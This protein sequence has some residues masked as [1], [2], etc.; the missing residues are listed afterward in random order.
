MHNCTY[1]VE[2]PV[3]TVYKANT[4]SPPKPTCATV[5][6]HDGTSTAH[7]EERG[8]HPCSV[9]FN[10]YGARIK[11]ADLQCILLLQFRYFLQHLSSCF[12]NFDSTPSS[13]AI[14]QRR[15][16]CHFTQLADFFAL[17]INGKSYEKGRSFVWW[18]YRWYSLCSFKRL[19]TSY[20]P[21]QYHPFSPIEI[22]LMV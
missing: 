22:F 15:L 4:D 5:R 11:K 21:D 7:E 18:H 8:V 20:F 13:S 12:A 1:S 17:F 6:L 3:T 9:S 14:T 16:V 19:L 10:L 2:I